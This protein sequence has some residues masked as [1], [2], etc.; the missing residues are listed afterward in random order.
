M[1]W[2]ELHI[3]K[4]DAEEWAHEYKKK[5]RFIVDESLGLEVA[6]VIR[7]EGWNAVSV[8]EVGLVGHPDED[9]LAYA[10]RDDRILLTHDRDFL[11]DH[12]FPPH[13]NP[14]L[15]VLPGAAGSTQVLEMELARILITAGHYR[16]AYCGYKI[17]IR[18]DGTW[19]IRHPKSPSGGRQARLLKF[20]WHGKIWEWQEGTPK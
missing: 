7:D 11:D 16:E 2:V 6:R 10:W 20:A 15:I 8:D 9:V 3:D 19:A 17:H 18:A 14:G 12:R 13:R 1:P 5:A 4:N